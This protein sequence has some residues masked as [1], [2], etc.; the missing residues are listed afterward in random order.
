MPYAL[1]FRGDALVM[2]VDAAGTTDAIKVPFPTDVAG[3]SRTVI[4]TPYRIAASG[5]PPLTVWTDRDSPRPTISTILLTIAQRL[6]V[7]Q[8]AVQEQ[9]L[10]L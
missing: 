3:V 7:L 10:A 6:A 4:F 8:M 1:L 2:A 5:G 9:R